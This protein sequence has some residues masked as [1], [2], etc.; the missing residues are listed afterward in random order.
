M[1]VRRLTFIRRTPT[2]STATSD[3]LAHGT[4]T[5]QLSMGLD[6]GRFVGDLVRRVRIVPNAVCIRSW[7]NEAYEAGS[8]M[9]IAYRRRGIR[10][11]C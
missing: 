6:R 9:S 1:A 11:E 3:S 5:S 7:P 8:G 2:T 10:I 4:K